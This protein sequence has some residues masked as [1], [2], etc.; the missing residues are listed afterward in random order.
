MNRIAGL[1]SFARK[2]AVSRRTTVSACATIDGQNCNSANWEKGMLIF[3]GDAAVTVTPSAT[4]TLKKISDFSDRNTIRRQTD[5]VSVPNGFNTGYLRFRGSGMIES[6]DA[7]SF[8]VCDE[9]GEPE[10]RALIVNSV[11][12]IHGATD[13]ND[14]GAV[15]IIFE[16][17]LTELTDNNVTCF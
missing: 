10:G 8:K 2:E 16:D 12:Q 13:S 1:L 4:N 14:N 11:G 6:A 15:E 3:I 7:G 9:R 5:S 17:V